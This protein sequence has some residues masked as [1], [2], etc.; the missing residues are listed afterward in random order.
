M[1]FPLRWR[2]AALLSAVGLLSAAVLAGR[3]RAARTHDPRTQPTLLEHALFA[4]EYVRHEVRLATDGDEDGVADLLVLRGALHVGAP[5]PEPRIELFSGRDG[6]FLR[7]LWNGKETSDRLISFESARDVDGDGAP[8]WIVECRER[9]DVPARIFSGLSTSP[10]RS[11]SKGRGWGGSAGDLDGNG[12]PDLYCDSFLPDSYERAGG[13][14]CISGREGR[15]LVTLAYPGWISE[16]G[17]THALGDFDG[18]GF[19]DLGVGDPNFHLSGPGDPGFTALQSSL[20]RTEKSGRRREDPEQPVVR[21]HARERLRLDLL[22]QDARG[23]LGRVGPA[24]F[25][26]WARLRDPAPSRHQRRRC[27]RRARHERHARVR[28]RGPGRRSVT[29]LQG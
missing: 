2:F 20:H 4:I 22:R 21:L 29:V 7:T 18:D 25:A 17:C 9:D 26:R 8:E 24:G 23:D 13:V 5:R 10:N 11:L 1:T 28:L 15:D 12:A 3:C 27:A 16:C 14:R 19:G 6:S